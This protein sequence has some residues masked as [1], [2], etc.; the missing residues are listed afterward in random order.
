MSWDNNPYYDP[1]KFGLELVDSIEWDGEDY[2]FHITAVWR[3]ARGKYYVATDSGCSC[4]SPFEDY[5]KLEDLDG[6]HNKRGLES[7][8][9]VKIKE[10]AREGTNSYYGGRSR[11]ELEKEVRELL[12]KLT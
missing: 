7:I 8:L 4:P 3:Q 11:A 9:R 5:D 10:N 6:P 2:Q 1:S 12:A